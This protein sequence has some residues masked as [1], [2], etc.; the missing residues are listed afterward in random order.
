M[1][2]ICVKTWGQVINVFNIWEKSNSLCN[3]LLLKTSGVSVLRLLKT[4]LPER[5]VFLTLELGK[6]KESWQSG[7]SS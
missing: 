7:H 1:K 3:Y 2:V 6:L 4:N 5:M